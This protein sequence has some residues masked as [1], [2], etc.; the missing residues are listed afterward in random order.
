MVRIVILTVAIVSGGIVSY[1][2]MPS[3]ASQTAQPGTV[4]EVL[5]AATPIKVGDDLK[6]RNFEW[7]RWPAESISDDLIE[8]EAASDA[9]DEFSG[10][11]AKA[12]FNAGEPIRKDRLLNSG[13]NVLSMSLESGRRAIA[14]KISA[15]NSA[16]GFILPNDR[17]DVIHTGYHG[18]K[19]G[20]G[21]TSSRT[22]LTNIRV[23]AIDQSSEGNERSNSV[24]GKTA[25]LELSPDQV[26]VVS[27]A[28]ASGTI[29]LALRAFADMSSSENRIH[30]PSNV[31]TIRI[32]KSGKLEVMRINY[33]V[34]D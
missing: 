7:R 15:G 22:I 26:E 16:G 2:S 20:G 33:G 24:V 32:F 4:K 11:V 31:R 25:T 18:Q 34:D 6:S 21:S 10:A 5:V 17:V 27:A 14:V 8:R 3:R 13:G 23:L 28:E 12:S 1:L 19:S 9:P 30:K 29:S